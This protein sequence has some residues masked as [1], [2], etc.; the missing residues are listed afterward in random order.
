M[1]LCLLNV[2][3]ELPTFQLWL[4][5]TAV[6]LA[7]CFYVYSTVTGLALLDLLIH[8]LIWSHLILWPTTFVENK[9]T[10]Y[11]CGSLYPFDKYSFRAWDMHSKCYAITRQIYDVF[12]LSSQP[13]PGCQNNYFGPITCTYRIIH[14][15]INYVVGSCHLLFP[16]TLRWHLF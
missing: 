5:L 6:L 12:L 15:N 7:R 16:Y 9:F 13:D 4:L 10:L 3:V 2:S 11:L 8:S 1:T 14:W